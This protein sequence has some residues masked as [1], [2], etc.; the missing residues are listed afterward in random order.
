MYT[1]RNPNSED[2]TD[3]SQSKRTD[4]IRGAQEEIH[5]YLDGNGLAG[6]R[7]DGYPGWTIPLGSGREVCPWLDSFRQEDPTRGGIASRYL[8]A[9]LEQLGEVRGRYAIVL[10]RKAEYEAKIAQIE[11]EIEEARA[12]AAELLHIEETDS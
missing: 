8:T 6:A 4:A 7:R 3:E 10:Q 9:K 12:I 2:Q 5:H 11:R 1:D